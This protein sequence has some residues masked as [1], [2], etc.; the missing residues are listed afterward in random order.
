[1]FPTLTHSVTE[2]RSRSRGLCYWLPKEHTH[3]HTHTF[4]VV[5]TFFS[6]KLPTQLASVSM[7]WPVGVLI[8]ALCL[9]CDS[10]N[11]ASVRPT[12]RLVLHANRIQE[13]KARFSLTYVDVCVCVCVFVYIHNVYTF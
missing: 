9:L 10:T 1:M 12:L 7:C 5:F 6:D 4:F 8:G 3:T 11:S 2:V 13:R